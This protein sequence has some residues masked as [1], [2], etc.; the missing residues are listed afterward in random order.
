M[1]CITYIMNKKQYGV[2]VYE[3]LFIFSKIYKNKST[4]VDIFDKYMYFR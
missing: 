1:Y 2:K 4:F 3:F